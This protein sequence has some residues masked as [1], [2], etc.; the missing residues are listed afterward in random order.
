MKVVE[1]IS[2]F[3]KVARRILKRSLLH[4]GLFLKWRLRLRDRALLLRRCKWE[5]W[6]KLSLSELLRGVHWLA[7]EEAVV[8]FLD[9]CDDVF[10]EGEF[11][12]LHA[13]KL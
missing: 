7:L 4:E 12:R 1:E 10:L 8:D 3:L 2:D 11:A 13:G 9:C 6:L 5:I